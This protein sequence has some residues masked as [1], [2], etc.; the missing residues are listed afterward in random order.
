M[1]FDLFML[2]NEQADD[3][4]KNDPELNHEYLPIAGLPQ[5]TSAAQKLIL[6]ADSPAIKDNR[7]LFPPDNP[8]HM[9]LTVYYR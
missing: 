5:Y 3:I 7:V 8:A 2:R 9:I 1:I 6:G 4:L